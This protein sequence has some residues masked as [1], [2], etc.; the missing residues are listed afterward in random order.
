MGA[1]GWCKDANGCYLNTV[2]CPVWHDT[3]GWLQAWG[4][5]IQPETDQPGLVAV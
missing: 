3:Y 1:W 5:V 2:S 4:A